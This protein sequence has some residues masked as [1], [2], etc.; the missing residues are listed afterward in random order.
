MSFRKFA[1]AAALA[2]AG[3]IA[4]ASA[5]FAYEA[6]ATTALNV[7]SGPGTNYNV[8]G[9]LQANQVVEVVECNTSGSWCRIQAP[10]VRGWSSANYLRP[11]SNG[12]PSRPSEP[13]VGISVQ[14]PNFSFSIGSG[15][16]PGATPPAS[17]RICFFENY[18][19]SGRRFCV[20]YGDSDRSL[21]TFWNNR[22]RSAEVEGD[23]AATICTGDDF[24]GQCAVIDRSVR[25]VGFLADEVSSYYVDRR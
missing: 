3:L 9:S 24:R 4:S 21:G 10:N 15:Q 16:R 14:T 8:V 7:R 1:A 25:S 17:G 23:I 2:I 12:T 20:G 22:I 13:E 19:Y 11:I 18:N 6:Y 5:A